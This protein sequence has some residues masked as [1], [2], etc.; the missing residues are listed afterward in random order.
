MQIKVKKNDVVW[1]YAGTFFNVCYSILLL[2]IVY[3]K[4]PLDQLGL[5]HVF[6]AVSQFTI[7]FDMGFSVTLARQ[8]AYCWS[9]VRTVAKQGIHVAEDESKIDCELLGKITL[10]CKI[11]YLA[12]ASA[13]GVLLLTLGRVYI[14]SVSSSVQVSWKNDAW[15]IFALSIALNLFNNYFY[16][17]MRGTG[18]IKLIN[19]VQILSKVLAIIINIVLLFLGYELM[20]VAI[21]HIIS[22]I[23]AFVTMLIMTGDIVHMANRGSGSRWTYCQSCADVLGK[24]WHNAYLEGIV[25]ISNYVNNYF[26]TILISLSG[27]MGQTAAYGTCVQLIN[28]VS[29]V[30]AAYNTAIRPSIQ[31][32]FA[33]GKKKEA[34]EEIGL[35]LAVYYLLFTL[36]TVGVL[37]LGIQLLT[38]LKKELVIDIY[39]YLAISAYTF[40]GKNHSLCASY[41]SDT[42]N[43]PFVKSY[44]VSSAIG[45]IL[46]FVLMKT[47][48]LGIYSYI[49]AIAVTQLCYNNWRW[50][51]YLSNFLNVPF[52]TI[53]AQGFSIIRKRIQG[54]KMK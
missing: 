24:M 10:S 46:S 45:L 9:G 50:P 39:M 40:L 53:C 6:N 8:I 3:K 30:S 32:M 49:L 23:F 42:N 27:N 34:A 25:T 16:S 43:L 28:I 4:L 22:S 41:I 48:S 33:K 1:N 26:G 36:G 2:P 12:I 17:L 18:R 47:T 20:S 44:V 15:S 54:L 52:P 14:D 13:A 7:L 19:V 38:F 5:W 21:S 35:S 37:T 51:K 29:N 11:I 31:S